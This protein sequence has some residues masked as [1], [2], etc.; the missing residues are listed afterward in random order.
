[1]SDLPANDP[2]FNSLRKKIFDKLYSLDGYIY[3]GY[4]YKWL[5]LHKPTNDIDIT[6]PDDKIQGMNEFLENTIK[7][8]KITNTSEYMCTKFNCS[9]LIIDVQPMSIT[10]KYHLSDFSNIMFGK[11]TFETKNG[12]S[13]NII[14]TY[15]LQNKNREYYF[16]RTMYSKERAYC[17]EN[18]IKII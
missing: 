16:N 12:E 9:D 3:G 2:S 8:K 4:V 1:M 6:I 17:R 11:K 14:M 7:C 13:A 5:L 18:D 10:K 15:I